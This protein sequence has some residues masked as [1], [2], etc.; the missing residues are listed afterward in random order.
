M[1]I[2]T[3]PLFFCMKGK[4]PRKTEYSHTCRLHADK[5]A[6]ATVFYTE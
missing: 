2:R 1:F 4:F 3:F 5:E 6:V